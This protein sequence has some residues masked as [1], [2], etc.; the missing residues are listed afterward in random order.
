MK[1]DIAAAVRRFPSRQEAIEEFAARNA[2]F[3]SLC[4]DLA[5]ADAALRR[6]ENMVDPRRDEH[7]AEYLA[8]ADDLAIE[9]GEVLKSAK[10]L[11]LVGRRSKPRL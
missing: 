4:T 1:H 8:M 2:E 5:D 11:P 9:V 7:V 3:V 6:W 10:I